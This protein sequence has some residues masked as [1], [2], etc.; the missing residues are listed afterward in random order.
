MLSVQEC[1]PDIDATHEAS[2]V[3][4][5]RAWHA[6][7]QRDRAAK[8]FVYAV[9]TTGVFC[10]CGCPSRKPAR[11]NVRF[12]PDAG[13]AQAAG[14][15]PCR[16]CRPG[17]ETSEVQRARAMLA[18]LDRGV[19]HTVTLQE[20]GRVA[21]CSPYTAQR[22]F[23]RVFGVT[24][25]QYAR[26][27]KA[28]LLRER[29]R[30]PSTSVTDA[31]YAAGYSGPGRAYEAS[32][33]TLGMRPGD[34]R[35]HGQGLRIRYCMQPFELGF[36]LVARTDKGICAVLLGDDTA[37]LTSELRD[38]FRRAEL[39]EDLAMSD[40]L[41]SV[42]TRC[43]HEPAASL[44]LPLDLQATAFQMRVWEALREIPPG[45]T[46]SYSEIAGRIGSPKSVRAVARACASNPAALIVPCHRVIGSKGELTGYRW[47]IERKRRLL[48]LEAKAAKH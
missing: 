46:R 31:I 9:V 35:R 43:Q 3:N 21:Q 4:A 23:Q 32:S 30:E 29:L 17:Q 38:R 14:F 37:R 2:P 47:G 26:Q 15:R 22:T 11:D 33:K 48:E 42:V 16:R 24:P 25:A 10:R 45:E 27:R 13:A 40:L 20:L 41:A 19:E 8:G 44:K 36:I 18:C 6:V 7:E 34:V 39:V 1:M 28:D 5:E 12:F